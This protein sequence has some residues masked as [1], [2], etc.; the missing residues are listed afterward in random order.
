M[1]RR[2]I[3]SNM[4]PFLTSVGVVTSVDVKGGVTWR[5]KCRNV[6]VRTCAQHLSPPH[7]MGAPRATV[8]VSAAP[9]ASL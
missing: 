9:P 4:G 1:Y 8:H 6:C 3:F 5:G 2:V 7:P